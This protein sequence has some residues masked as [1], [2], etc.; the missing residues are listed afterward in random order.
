MVNQPRLTTD[1]ENILVAQNSAE[2][3]EMAFVT[4]SDGNTKL[5]PADTVVSYKTNFILIAVLEETIFSLILN[6][7]LSLSLTLKIRLN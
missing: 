2:S 7:Y 4:D 1:E 3:M 6:E 5:M